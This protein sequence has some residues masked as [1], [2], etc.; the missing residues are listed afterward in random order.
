MGN[1]LSGDAIV[2]TSSDD[3]DMPIHASG[4]PSVAIVG[5]P[6]GVSGSRTATATIGAVV[7]NLTVFLDS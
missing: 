6:N 3:I 5:N 1:V 2:W 7:G 4:D